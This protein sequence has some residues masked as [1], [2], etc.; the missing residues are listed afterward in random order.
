MPLSNWNNTDPSG[1]SHPC[2]R[3]DLFSVFQRR[4]LLFHT[5]NSAAFC[6]LNTMPRIYIT[7]LCDMSILSFAEPYHLSFNTSFIVLKHLRCWQFTLFSNPQC[8]VKPFLEFVVVK[9]SLVCCWFIFLGHKHIIYQ[10]FDLSPIANCK[11]SPD[12]MPPAEVRHWSWQSLHRW[13]KGWYNT[14]QNWTD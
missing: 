8:W 5:L 1:R 6:L 2:L 12:E 13:L 10:F 7:S 9:F 4:G 3:K 14:S 11:P